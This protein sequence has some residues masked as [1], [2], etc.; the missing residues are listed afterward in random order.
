MDARIIQ[1]FDFDWRF[2]L[3]DIPGAEERAY[4]DSS[5]RS[6]DLP[7]DWS[8][9]GPFLP[10]HPSGGDGGYAPCG[11]G[12]YRKTFT[13]PAQRASGRVLLE[14]DG[15]Y[16]S[17]TVWVNGVRVGRHAY[18]YTSFSLDITDATSRGPAENVV[19]VR[20][21]NSTQPGSRWYSGSGIYRHT[22]L[23]CTDSLHFASEGIFA[24]SIFPSAEDARLDVCTRVSNER[25]EGATATL[26]S[27]LV[28]ESGSTVGSTQSPLDVP[29]GAVNSVVHA[30]AV[31][32]PKL[33]ST[34]R[35]SLYR[36]VSEIVEGERVVDRFE[37][38]VGMR[39]IAF[40]AGTGFRLNGRS[41]KIRGVCLHHDG[42]CVGA[43]VPEEVLEKRLTL[44]KA[45]GC[46]AV[47]TSHNPP[48]REL[49][50]MCDR[51]GILVMDEAFDEWGIGKEKN[52]DA[53]FGYHTVFESDAEGDLRDMI[54]R[55]RNHPSI[56]LWSIGNEIPEQ[57]TPEG[58]A[59]AKKM[60]A[61]VHEE[62]VTR[63]VTSA[64]DHIGAEP[65]AT[66][67]SFLEALDVV[68]YNYVDRW[69]LRTETYYEED[70]ARF[71]GRRIIGSESVSLGGPRGDIDAAFSFPPDAVGAAFHGRMVLAEQL[72]KVTET[73]DYVAGDF[74]WTGVDYLGE[75]RWP[76]RIATS[77]VLDTCGF[78]KDGYYLYQ[79]VWT[80]KPVLHVFPHWNHAEVGKIVRV[81]CFTNCDEVELFLN[82]RSFGKK[83]L[84]FPRQGMS[85]RYGHYDRQ[86]VHPT[87]ADLHLSWDVPFEP[88]VLSAVGTLHGKPWCRA[89]IRTTAT[90]AA[91][92]LEPDKIILRANRRDVSHVVVRITDAAGNT[93][94][95]ADNRVTLAVEGE[96]RLIG[97][98]NGRPDDH[99]DYRSYERAAFNGLCLA[100]VRSTGTPGPVRITASSP[101]LSGGECEI[102]TFIYAAARTGEP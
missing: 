63:P 41:I 82:A 15:V 38:S 62:D 8:I 74:M 1:C 40:D 46:N 98:D 77:G 14:F 90:P 76:R 102:R 37:I 4:P 48:S 23:I 67:P 16:M 25:A 51:M 57:D 30:I 86:Y 45:M 75:S 92:H 49:L 79:S 5:W 36:L 88:G 91:I 89:E 73:R 70:H 3:G 52:G 22:R 94:P 33:W 56:V 9:E 2:H 34:E 81:F 95:T 93:V 43:A 21:D 24:C 59:L 50:D 18:G 66:D 27:L 55:D 54:R 12:W 58:G 19:A 69:R 72:L 60:A 6:V 80:G 29:P 17:C 97:F 26:R 64:C 47:R 53:R 7:H 44:L 11:I 96:G 87:T 84:Q 68:G 99:T 100:L 32:E 39:S 83:H 42:G 61:I 35:P 31:R 20:V 71:P 78:V 65:V 10:T 28:D 13:V 101:G 85:E